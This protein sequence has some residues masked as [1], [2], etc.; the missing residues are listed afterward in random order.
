[1]GIAA[2]VIKD[3]IGPAGVRLITIEASYPRIILAEANTHRWLSRNTAS[4]RAI[5]VKKMIQRVME[6]PF[7]PEYWGKNQAGMQAAEELSGPELE[8][9]KYLWLAARDSAVEFAQHLVN[10]G[11]HKQIANRL[12]EPFQYI[13]SIFTGTEQ[14]WANLR[15]QRT[16]HAAQPEFRVLAT[17]IGEAIDASIPVMLHEGDWHLPYIYEADYADGISPHY[18]AEIS[19]AR[20]ARVS[21]LN[22]DGVRSLADDAALY[23][24]LVNHAMDGSEPGHWSPLEHVAQALAA[25]EHHGNFV[26][27]KQLRKFFTFEAG[28]PAN[29]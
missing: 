17:H 3:S 1:M 4:S 23:H 15:F 2:K 28:P 6:D 9:C 22:H 27:W 7:M 21:Y 26:G 8:A 13:T 19:A 20:C 10:L 24:K 12:L 18:L 16:H 11:L 25:P 5:P 29:V 14:A